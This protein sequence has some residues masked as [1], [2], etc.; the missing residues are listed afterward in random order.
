MSWSPGDPVAAHVLRRALGP[1]RSH[2]LRSGRRPH[3]QHRRVRGQRAGR[4]PELH[5]RRVA[6]VRR[7]DEGQ[8]RG[9]RGA[10]ARRGITDIDLVLFDVWT[11]GKALMPEQYRDR[12][13]GWCDVWSA[14]RP[15]QPVRE[16]GRR[17]QVHR[18]HEHDASC[19]R[20]TTTAASTPAPGDGRVRAR[21]RAGADA[22]RRHQAAAHHPAG[23]V[24]FTLDGRRAAL[25]AAG[26]CGSAST[27]ARV[28]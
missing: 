21:P 9:D 25:A 2:D 11:Y 10:L 23:G 15:R 24:S 6:R 18:R 16:P 26:R 22:A 3:R 14:R 12:R 27:T 17:S 19:S 5:R 13:L 28:R 20:S 4:H 8:P 1:Q 7:G